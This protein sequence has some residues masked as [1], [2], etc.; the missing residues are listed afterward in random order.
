MSKR[1]SSGVL[2][3]SKRRHTADEALGLLLDHSDELISC[4]QAFFGSKS[5]SSDRNEDLQ[6][7]RRLS[8]KLLP[9]FK[10]LAGEGPT[11][12]DAAQENDV[13]KNEVSKSKMDAA[14]PT[15]RV[16]PTSAA[17]PIPSFTL[18]TPWTPADIPNSMPP[19]PEISNPVLKMAAFTHVGV[20][21]HK[22]DLSYDRLEWLGDAYVELISSSLI[23][24]TFG[25]MPT[26]KC[27]QLR[28]LL[29][30]NANLGEYSAHYKLFER[31]KLPAEFRPN[32]NLP[33]VAKPHEIKKVRGDL[34]EAYVAAVVLSDPVHGLPRAAEWLKALWAMTIKDQIRTSARNPEMGIVK[35]LGET[36]T[37]E[38]QI[39]PKVRLS[40][41]IG[42][43]G[44]TIRYEDLP[45]V[46]KKDKYNKKLALF[47][48]G[49]FLDGWGEKNKLLGTGSDLNKKEAGQ[50]AAQMA[51]DNKKLM[52]VYVEKK[53]A[54]MA[55]LGE[56]EDASD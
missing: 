6:N 16:G 55:A 40:Q 2:P 43:K 46:N 37:E 1:S 41:V 9:S 56:T 12:A 49:V 23:F 51:L 13:S 10:H 45:S 50:K 28:E 19:L 34:F 26:G 31:A 30:R 52:K 14:L 39:A 17:P 53:K 8:K 15:P 35:E 29:I 42:A 47:S 11:Q 5:A 25:G 22:S 4:L 44:I 20:V 7:L 36:V 3:P 27:S 38:N 54:L 33:V 21:K 48:V 32:G 18:V 24:Q